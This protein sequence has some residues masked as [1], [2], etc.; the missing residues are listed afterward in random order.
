MSWSKKYKK[1]INC[2]N[3]KGFSQRAHCQGRKKRKLKEFKEYIIEQAEL[4]NKVSDFVDFATNY[5]GLSKRPDVT[6]LTVR[7]PNMTTAY[8]NIKDGN[9]KIYSKGRACFDICRSIAHEMVHQKQHE[10]IENPDDLDGS[11]GSPHEDEANAVA[12]R[13][14]RTYGEQVPGFYE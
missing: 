1:S 8:Y 5:L 12:G 9:I 6:L 3:P 7:E 11:T 14:I 4:E 10:E 13:M 2:D